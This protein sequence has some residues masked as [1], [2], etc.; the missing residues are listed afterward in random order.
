M[1]QA[2]KRV[3][4]VD[5]YPS[6]QRTRRSCRQHVRKYILLLPRTVLFRELLS[7]ASYKE[8][9]LV[10]E[11][12]AL[13]ER[14]SSGRRSPV[15]TG[16]KI[17]LAADTVIVA[18]GEQVDSTLLGKNGI[19]LDAKGFPKVGP[20]CETNIPGVYVAGDVK[21]GPAT[22]VRAIADGKAVAKDILQKEGLEADFEKKVFPVDEKVL[23]ERKG[24]LNNPVYSDKEAER[25]LSCENICE[26]CVDVCPNRANAVIF[27]DEGFASRHQVIHLDG[28]CNE[29]GNCG[30]FCPHEGNPYKDKVTVFWNE[31]DFRDSTNKGFL[32]TDMA[33]CKCLVR[34]EE[35]QIVNYALGQEY[36]VSKDMAA[37]IKAC[38]G[39]YSFML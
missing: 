5:Q 7:P 31:E 12:M 37:I 35:D 3:P 20:A 34:T 17:T 10:C 28:M 23:Y 16:K 9:K 33:A 30:I 27:V 2:A 25:C 29:C 1:R 13:G 39:K 38:I 15:P 8:G 24:I 26:L 18:V 14:D 36:G 32:V 22:I 4:G 19:E 6:I 11:V 21:K